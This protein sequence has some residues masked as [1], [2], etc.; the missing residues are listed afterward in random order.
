MEAGASEYLGTGD[1][2]ELWAICT[3]EL[4]G[5]VG[6]RLLRK[7]TKEAQ[8]WVKPEKHKRWW[9]RDFYRLFQ[10][11]AFKDADVILA[12]CEDGRPGDRLVASLGWKKYCQRDGI[13]YY[14]LTREER[15]RENI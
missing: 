4:I 10:A 11:M 2:V 5:V 9:T 1:D 12:L 3:P 7:R 8:L 15:M 14:L 6:F 13:V